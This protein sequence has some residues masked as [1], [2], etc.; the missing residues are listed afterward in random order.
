MRL[1]TRSLKRFST[2]NFY[3]IA[4]FDP[5]LQELQKVVRKFADERVAP[6]AAEVDKTDKFPHHLW[7]E[8]GEMGILGVTT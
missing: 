7:R 4:N 3:S 5:D 8:F 1:V 6:L 2:T